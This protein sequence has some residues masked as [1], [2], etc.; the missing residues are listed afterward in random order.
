MRII[1]WNVRYDNKRT[2]EAVQSALEYKPDLLCL[3]EVPQQTLAWLREL[4]GYYVNASYDFTHLRNPNKNGYICTVTR[5]KPY[6]VSEVVYDKNTYSSLLSRVLYFMITHKIERHTA[7]IIDI[8]TPKGK[9]Q[10]VNTRLSCAVGTSDRLLE[11]ETMKQHIHYQEIPTIFC[12]DFNVVDSNW[13]NRITGWLRGFDSHDYKINE[14]QAFESLYKDAH[15]VNVFHGQS[16][17]FFRK[18]LL[19]LDHILTPKNA[20]VI[21]SEIAKD[22]YGSDHRML[23]LDFT[24]PENGQ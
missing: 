16:T 8:N 20:I 13:F 15:L 1:T 4:Q 5:V 3:Q 10:I 12:G 22:M 14:R 2:I 18:P 21:H 19:Q 9:L 7:L 24:M 6:D 23:L 17:M 11:F